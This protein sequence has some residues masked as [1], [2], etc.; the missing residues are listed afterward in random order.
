M[1]AYVQINVLLKE[2]DVQGMGEGR[3]NGK[4]GWGMAESIELVLLEDLTSA[5]EAARY[6]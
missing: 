2:L 1:E 6:A 4:A 5:A 3:W